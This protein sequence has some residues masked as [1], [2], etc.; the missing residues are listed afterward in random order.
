MYSQYCIHI[1]DTIQ[2]YL[3]I[4]YVASRLW[5]I[6]IKCNFC[7]NSTY[8]QFTFCRLQMGQKRTVYTN[9]CTQKPIKTHT[10]TLYSVH[11]YSVQ[12]ARLQCAAVHTTVETVKSDSSKIWTHFNYLNSMMM[13]IMSCPLPNDCLLAHFVTNK[14]G[15]IGTGS[16]RERIL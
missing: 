15:L 7:S 16:N 3:K 6:W 9:K 14:S 5:W 10:C 13:M 2:P 12:R 11:L 4:N 1:Y 8:I